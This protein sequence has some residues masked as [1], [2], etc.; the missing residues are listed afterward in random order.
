MPLGESGTARRMHR[1]LAILQ[2]LQSIGPD[3]NKI[4]SMTRIPR[5][6]VRYLYKEHILK[7][8]IRV[9]R[10]IDHE[11]LGLSYIQFLVKFSPG[12][13]SLFNQ[14]EASFMGLWENIYSSSV[15]RVIPE[16]YRFIGHLAPPSFHP[17]LEQFYERLEQIGLCKVI[18]KY[19]VD[20]LVHNPMW[21]EAFD[22]ERNTW[23][24]DWEL[25]GRRPTAGTGE[26]PISEPV[27]ID[28]TDI[29]IIKLHGMN[30][31]ANMTKLAAKM[32][33]KQPTFAYH[34]REHLMGR[35]L[36]KG[37][38]IRWLGTH[39]DPKTGQIMRR[40]SSAAINVVAKDLS[41]VEMMN[42]R[43]QLHSI[44]FLWGEQIGTNVGEVNAETLVPGNELV[45]YFDFLGK[46]TTQL[47]DKVR[48]MMIDQ[49]SSFVQT[50]H[51]HLFDESRGGWLY[52]GDLLLEAFERG[53][54]DYA[55]SDG[56]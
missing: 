34:W 52:M 17:R 33:M 1:E 29:E 20:H 37:W 27:E 22:I 9:Q 38:Y 41:P 30:P 53:A 42:F 55:F 32:K 40:R 11:K 5:E 46:I 51:P 54:S 28:R 6:T 31:G 44:P 18:E 4:S 8:R 49:Q 3:I 12:V 7:K 14:P 13:E 10:E 56:K 39:R 50:L 35:G 43:A 47:E 19:H 26:P 48:V 2:Q 15:Y 16:N 45:D 36:F 25:K 24:F 23:D 21:V